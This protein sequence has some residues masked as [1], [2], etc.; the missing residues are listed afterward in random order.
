MNQL[1]LNERE[2]KTHPYLIWYG[3]IL[4][5]TH[6]DAHCQYSRWHTGTTVKYEKSSEFRTERRRWKKSARR[7]I[8]K[9]NSFKKKYICRSQW[10][11]PGAIWNR[12]WPRCGEDDFLFDPKQPKHEIIQNLIWVKVKSEAEKNSNLR[13]SEPRNRK[14]KRSKTCGYLNQEKPETR[15][16][17]ESNDSKPILQT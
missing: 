15:E 11:D 12:K 7:I 6:V 9:L 10:T 4:W 1:L 3:F 8:H 14:T 17:S 13:R 16:K 5:I 2:S